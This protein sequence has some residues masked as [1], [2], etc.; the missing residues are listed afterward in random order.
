MSKHTVEIIDKGNLGKNVIICP[1]CGKE[2]TEDFATS[3]RTVKTHFLWDTV[4]SGPRHRCQDPEC[5]CEFY[6]VAR[7]TREWHGI[8]N[9]LVSIILVIALIA[10][11][12]VALVFLAFLI[13]KHSDPTHADVAEYT[14]GQLRGR[15]YGSIV[16]IF[17]TC[18]LIDW[19]S[20]D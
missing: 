2:V 14:L 12:I 9:E 3:Y 7:V 11:C 20:F 15:F 10:E 4:L 5:H 1:M 16:S 19:E 6:E 8:Q 17:V 13:T 18:F